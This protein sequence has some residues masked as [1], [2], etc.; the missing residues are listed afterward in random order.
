MT[1]LHAIK[2]YINASRY[3]LHRL[4]VHRQIETYAL[5]GFMVDGAFERDEITYGDAR[6]LH[7]HI[8]A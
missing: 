5:L 2:E 6:H 7:D 4:P 1:T 3:T 8:H